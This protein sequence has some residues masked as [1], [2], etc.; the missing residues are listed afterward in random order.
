MKQEDVKLQREVYREDVERLAGWMSDE[1][2]VEH[3][4][5]E[6]NIDRK[7]QDLLAQ[8]HLPL[9]SPHFNRD[10]SF[11]LVTLPHEGPIGFVRLVP[12][13]H[14]AEIVVVIGERRHWGNGYGY[15][16]IRKGVRYAFFEWRKEKVVAT[17]HHDNRRSRK[18][19]RQ[20][21]FAE[22]E[23]LSSETRFTLPVERFLGH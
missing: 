3:L 16:A 13:R 23:E 17:I 8:S 9:F 6:Q 4:N 22:A 21:G 11:F 2:V 7:L 12:K 19:F 15:Q 20:V 18:V 14:K 10:G 1:V 5:E